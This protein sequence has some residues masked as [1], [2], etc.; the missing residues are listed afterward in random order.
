MNG[1]KAKML[2]KLAGPKMDTQYTETNVRGKF[3]NTSA[4][5]DARGNPVLDDEG[6]ET[7]NRVTWRTSTTMMGAGTRMVYKVLKNIYHNRTR[8]MHVNIHTPVGA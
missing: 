6:N 2:R 7:F 3:M 8:D 5:I 1:K 4:I